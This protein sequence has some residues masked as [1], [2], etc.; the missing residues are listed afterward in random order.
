M[1]LKNITNFLLFLVTIH[2]SVAQV[3]V[4]GKVIDAAN[5]ES[6]ESSIISNGS[7]FVL[8]NEN[9]FFELEVD[10]IPINLSINHLGY[11]SKVITVST[12]NDNLIIPLEVAPTQLHEVVVTASQQNES[13]KNASASIGVI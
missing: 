13:L 7:I 6:L 1:T 10:S 2:L 5:Q 4:K 3:M 11:Y 9:G 12:N 8:A